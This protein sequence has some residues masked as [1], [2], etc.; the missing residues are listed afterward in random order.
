MQKVRRS[1]KIQE[2]DTNGSRVLVWTPFLRD[3]GK[4]AAF[5]SIPGSGLKNELED[6]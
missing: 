4:T 2:R 5:Q 6:R 3:I 1:G